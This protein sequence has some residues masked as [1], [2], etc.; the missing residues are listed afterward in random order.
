MT[1]ADVAGLV[2]L[3][4]V[5]VGGVAYVV[6]QKHQTAPA[7]F[8]PYVQQPG[9]PTYGGATPGYGS[10]G[11]SAQGGTGGLSLPPS[12]PPAQPNNG[13]QYASGEALAWVTG[14]GGLVNSLGQTALGF[15]SQFGGGA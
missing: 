5:L 4:V 6:M 13:Q 10:P 9:G 1:S 11:W 8:G 7:N 15:A 12:Q 3:G 14:I 2:V